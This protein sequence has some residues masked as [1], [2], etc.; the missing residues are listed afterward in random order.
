MATFWQSTYLYTLSLFSLSGQKLIVAELLT[1]FGS[2]IILKLLQVSILLISC[3][4]NVK[5]I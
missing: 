4:E 2:S 1:G 3:M 5:E